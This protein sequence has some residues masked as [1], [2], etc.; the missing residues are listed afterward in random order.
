MRKPKIHIIRLWAAG[1]IAKC[2]RRVPSENVT[3]YPE[4]SDCRSCGGTKGLKW[5]RGRK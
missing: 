2:G 4:Q 3:A 5:K 1:A